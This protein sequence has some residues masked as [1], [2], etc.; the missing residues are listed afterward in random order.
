MQICFSYAIMVFVVLPVLSTALNGA[1]PAAG[2]QVAAVVRTDA[3][4]RLVRSVTVSPL[5]VAPKVIQSVAVTNGQRAEEAKP[6]ASGSVN[7]LVARIARRHDVEPVLVD[8]MIRVESNYNPLAVSHKGAEGLMQLVPGT[9]RR[10]GVANT[11]SPAQNIEGGVRYLKYL[12][13]LFKG[14]QRLALAAYNA[15]EGAV[16]KYRG[17]PPYAETRNYVY[18]VGKRLGEARKMER[19]TKTVEPKPV[20][21]YP[22]IVRMVDAD[23]KEYYRSR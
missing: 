5:A 21:E 14:D 8:S 16:A 11:F 19:Q 22:P 7:E 6:A 13:E 9:A 3:R 20:R 2:R 12:L 10:F 4:G 18:Q 1:A 23:G 15:G 17:I